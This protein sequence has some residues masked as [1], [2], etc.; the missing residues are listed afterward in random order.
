[1][2]LLSIEVIMII[3]LVGVP[4]SLLAILIITRVN[5]SYE[6]PA[7]VKF[8]DDFRREMNAQFETRPGRGIKPARVHVEPAPAIIIFNFNYL[9]Y[10]AFT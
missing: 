5:A 3:V 10:S 6:Q 8:V 7:G 1:M 4:M 9:R 2:L